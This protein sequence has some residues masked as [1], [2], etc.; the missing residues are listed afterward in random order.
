MVQQSR[1]GRT[2]LWSV[3]AI[4]ALMLA[5]SGA[6]AEIRNMVVFGD[7]LSD[8]GNLN[9]IDNTQPTR[10]SNGDVWVYHLAR[11]IGVDLQNID[12][13]AYIGAGV[14]R[15]R[16]GDNMLTDG[17][18]GNDDLARRY[19]SGTLVNQVLTYTLSSPQFDPE[20]TLFAIWIGLDDMIQYIDRA[21]AGDTTLEE[22]Q[23]Y[24]RN[25]QADIEV[26]IRTLQSLGAKRFLLI[27]LPDIAR[28]VPLRIHPDIGI[29]R[30]VLQLQD[31]WNRGMSQLAFRRGGGGT[32]IHLF[33]ASTSM[34]NIASSGLYRNTFG[35]YVAL[36]RNY[37]RLPVTHLLP[38]NYFWWDA[39]HPMTRVHQQLA[40][41]MFQQF[42]SS[43]ADRWQTLG[44]VIRTGVTPGVSTVDP[45]G[46]FYMLAD[47]QRQGF[48]TR[49]EMVRF[50]RSTHRTL[51]MMDG[52]RNYAKR[53][54]ANRITVIARPGDQVTFR[55]K[56]L[57]KEPTGSPGTD[58]GFFFWHHVE[59]SY[60]LPGAQRRGTAKLVGTSDA[61]IRSGQDSPF[62]RETGFRTHTHTFTTGG[63]FRVGV[64]V[65][66]SGTN[67][68]ASAMIVDRIRVPDSVN[69]HGDVR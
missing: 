10:L 6:Q 53:G 56:F 68:N 37:N 24:V 28:M 11:R 33:D 17:I 29:R 59:S 63:I 26:A 2:W 23:I 39:Y 12:N 30:L 38:E 15:H 48:A 1:R 64:G 69:Y 62:V 22:R 46:Y 14:A 67:R 65:I 47:G 51:H 41:E 27:N 35:T 7:G 18:P 58:Y 40:D 52:D 34:R 61:T 45:R 31:D 3:V 42:F 21:A 20:T 50:T 25:E 43:T 9:R 8:F 32:T 13:N 19:N 4:L 55:Y 5:T 54:A 36:D 60:D 57:T 49:G 66:N 16:L 44:Q